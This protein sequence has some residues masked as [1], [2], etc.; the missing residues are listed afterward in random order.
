MTKLSKSNRFSWKT[1]PVPFVMLA[2]M[3]G[4]TDTVFRQMIS[5]VARPDIM[6]TEFVN[7]EGFCSRGKAAIS[8]SLLFS[9]NERPLLVQL[10][11]IHPEN[12][13]D[14]AYEVKEAG[15]DGIDINM[16][17]PQRDVIKNGACGALI[18]TPK[19]AENIIRAIRDAVPDMPL[20]VKTRIG[21]D[22]V[23]TE[24]WISFLLSMPIDS[25]IIHGRT[26]REM[27][28]TPAHWDEIQKAV[29][30]RNSLRSKIIIVGNGDVKNRDDAILKA[31][32]YGTDGIMIGRGVFHDIYAFASHTQKQKETKKMLLGLL[33]KHLEFHQSVWGENKSYQTLKKFFKTYVRD[34]KGATELRMKL[35]GTQSVK[36]ALTLLP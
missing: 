17:C 9:D 23:Q 10:W 6:V 19:K 2:P 7:V 20:S 26:V 31:R 14:A 8:Q 4:V 28:K 18:K 29:H 33:R 21:F 24:E 32:T 3:E 35:M 22:T 30:L 27:S 11:G 16:G 36:E 12:F 34:F 5:S 15:F 13:A 25:L 1:I